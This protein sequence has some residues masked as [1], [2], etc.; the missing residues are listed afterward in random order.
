MLR[1]RTLSLPKIVLGLFVPL[2]SLVA[3]L[4]PAAGAMADGPAPGWE[5]FGY[6]GPTKLQ[7]GGS[8]VIRVYVYSVGA[9]ANTGAVVVVEV[10]P[11]GFVGG[12]GVCGG[13]GSG[14]RW[15]LGCEGSEV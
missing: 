9:E 14:E 15:V 1:S 11:A 7:P 8:G 10:L 4:V 5:V 6:F 3:F 2:L 13:E 12:P